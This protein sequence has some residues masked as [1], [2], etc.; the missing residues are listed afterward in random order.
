MKIAI[1]QNQLEDEMEIG[2]LSEV[3][4]TYF[5]GKEWTWVPISDYTKLPQGILRP[6]LMVLS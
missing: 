1:M 4:G 3:T 6:P 2:I 5:P